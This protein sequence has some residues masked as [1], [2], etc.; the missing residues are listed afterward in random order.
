[1][2]IGI[3]GD[4]SK[5]MRKKHRKA[6]INVVNQL[7]DELGPSSDGYRFAL[8]TFGSE[9]TIE[10]NFQDTKSYNEG[11]LKKEVKERIN[12]KPKRFGT[13]TDIAM[14]KAAGEL[15][16]SQGGDRPEANNLM[17]VITDGKPVKKRWDKK[18][19]IPFPKSTEALEVTEFLFFY[20][21]FS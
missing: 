6:L 14:D 20:F 10:F 4:I 5:S 21:N 15:Y 17:L 7:I 13:R 2:D 8:G 16:T 3:L 19:F 18:P 1:M 9:G 12:Y 11:P